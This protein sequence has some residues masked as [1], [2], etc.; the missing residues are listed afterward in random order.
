MQQ[1]AR[2]LADARRRRLGLELHLG[3][4]GPAC[5]QPALHVGELGRKVANAVPHIAHLALQPLAFGADLL[6]T[7]LALEDLLLHVLGGQHRR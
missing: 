3:E 5:R 6:E 4:D 2:R 1:I 7:S